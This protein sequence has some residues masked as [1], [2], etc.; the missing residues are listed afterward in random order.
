MTYT[1]S[2]AAPDPSLRQRTRSRIAGLVL[3]RNWK[4]THA[5]RI[6]S[7]E[8]CVLRS[9]VALITPAGRPWSY[10]VSSLG[11]NRHIWGI[12]FCYL[13]CFLSFFLFWGKVS[14]WPELL[15][16]FFFLLCLSSF[17]HSQTVRTL[18][19]GEREKE[20]VGPLPLFFSTLECSQIL[21]IDPVL[22]A[23]SM[24]FLSKPSTS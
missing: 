23:I 18:S 9:R 10:W 24:F 12:S 7:Q 20:G 15:F 16:F 4:C 19:W 2:W 8:D 6:W 22:T 11:Q 3:N 14:V 5:G 1:R 21:R 13:S 17:N